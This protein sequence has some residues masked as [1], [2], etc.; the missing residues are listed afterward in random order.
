M[1][2]KKKLDVSI[3]FFV[4]IFAIISVVTINS[5]LTYLS[6]DVGNLALKQCI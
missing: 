5:A 1:F 6:S 2:R 3:L 4:I